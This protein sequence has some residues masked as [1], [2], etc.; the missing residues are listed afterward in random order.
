MTKMLTGL[1]VAATAISLTASPALAQKNTR[2]AGSLA[3]YG[4]DTAK[5]FSQGGIEK[6]KDEISSTQFDHGL[7]VT[8]D[9]YAE[10]PENKKAAYSKDKEAK[11]FKDWAKELATSDKDKGIYILVCR[12]PGF[13]EV[14]ADKETRNRGFSNADE[15]KLRDILLKGFREAKDKPEAEQLDIRDAALA[16]A[17]EMIVSDLKGTKVSG[18]G[19]VKPNTSST[20]A[21]GG[22]GIMGWVCIGIACLLGVWLVIGIFRA[23]TGGGGGGGMGGGGMGGGGGGG[24]FLTSLMGGMFGAV[25]GMWMYNHFMGGGSM[26]GG[27]D[28]YASDNNSYGDS[29]GGDTGAG[30]YSGDDGAGGSFD[31][32]G[33]GDAGGGGDWGGGG[34]DFGGGGGDF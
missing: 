7:S 21:S 33:G 10:L 22:M 27:S 25:A 23:F 34:G 20:K 2:Q 5:L 17:I 1:V 31:G 4:N 32:G 11:F 28:A 26:F 9:T 6:A 18:G 8:I 19:T 12:K 16:S 14:I 3:V 30:D 15:Q 24:G 29:G 13:I